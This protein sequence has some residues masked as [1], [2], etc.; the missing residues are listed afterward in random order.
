MERTRQLQTILNTSIQQ[1]KLTAS[2]VL[3]HEPISPEFKD[4]VSPNVDTVYSTAWLDLSQNP[5]V[6]FVPDTNDRY[7]LVQ[8]M[9]AYSNTFSSIGRRTTGTKADKFAIVGP[10]W[11]GALSSGLKAVKS[12]TNTAWL[13]VRV[14]S[15]GKG[16]EEE[17]LKI[18]NQFKLTSLD[19]TSSPHVI[20]PANELLLNNK[21]EDLSAMYFFKTMTDL[22][23]L[24]PTTGNEP[25]EKQFEYIGIDRTYGFDA[26][27][28]H[29]DI[30]AGLNRAAKDAFAIIS[31]SLEELNP[32][33][34]NGWMIITG[35]GAYGDQFLKRAFVAY[36]GLGANINEDATCPR[37]FTDDQGNQLNGKY[38]YI[39]HFDKAAPRRSFLVDNNV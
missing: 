23:I 28:L 25:F 26:G 16:D 5:V 24:N 9:D 21:V 19:E 38:N 1:P 10:D 14:L 31:N 15:K 2:N 17:A 36:M 11:K 6:L 30:I 3:F 7:Y 34:S 27:K 13:I 32:R 20:K 37:A 12:P 4:V 29:P 35:I 8:I 22:M 33:I 39:M 18:L